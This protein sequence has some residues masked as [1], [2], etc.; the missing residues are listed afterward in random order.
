M[1]PHVLRFVAFLLT[2]FVAMPS[3]AQKR[4][5]WI[6]DAEG[7]RRT[8]ATTFEPNEMTFVPRFDDGGGAGLGVAWFVTGRVAFEFKAAALASQLTVRRTGSDFI[9]VGDLGYTQIY[10]ISLVVQWH[11]IDSGSV[12]PYIGAG[13]AYVILR[14]VEKSAGG[15]TGVAFDDPTGLVVNAG[16]RIPFSNRW[17]L[18]GD[19]RYV[20]VETRGRARFAGTDAS[21]EMDVRPLI[22]GVGLAYS[23]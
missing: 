21:V 14:D 4:V 10:P 3:A 23:F 5:E 13:V 15:V 8:G 11:P 2:L 6:V 18:N 12:R 17:S 9:T 22:V 1:R 16:L 20:P 19:V 7:V